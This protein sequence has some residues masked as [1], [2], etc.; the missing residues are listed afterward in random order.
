[1]KIRN[2]IALYVICLTAMIPM[3]LSGLFLAGQYLIRRIMLEKLEQEQAITFQIPESRLN[4]INNKK[5]LVIQGKMFDV[6]SIEKRGDIYIVSGLFDDLET[7]LHSRLEKNHDP[8]HG[9][10][11][12]ASALFQVCLGIIGLQP[13]HSSTAFHPP[14]ARQD[15]ATLNLVPKLLKQSHAVTVPPPEV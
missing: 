11:A 2:R 9:T 6:K 10:G 4:W 7:A 14:A 1:M 12:G 3:F 5:E 15:H 13:L 8:L